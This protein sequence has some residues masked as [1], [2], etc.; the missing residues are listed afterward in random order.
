MALTDGMGMRYRNGYHRPV[1]SAGL[2]RRARHQSGLSLR[3]LGARAGT[4]HATLSDYEHGRRIPRVDTLDR[5]L[6]A[7]G[8]DADVRLTGRADALDARERK[9]R[10]LRE[11][12]DLAAMFPARRRGALEFPPFPREPR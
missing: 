6:K 7:A 3:A 9:G 2:I 8:F 5:I 11:A 4:S 1:D 10:E 12:L